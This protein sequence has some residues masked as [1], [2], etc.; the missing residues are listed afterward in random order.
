MKLMEL[1]AKDEELCVLRDRYYELTGRGYPYDMYA[2]HGNEDYRQ[3]LKEQIAELE[4]QSNSKE[5]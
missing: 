2:H 3:R 1:L 5:P 4:K